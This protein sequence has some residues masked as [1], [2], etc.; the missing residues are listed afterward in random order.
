MLALAQPK[1]DRIG[2]VIK[3]KVMMVQTFV[4]KGEPEGEKSFW[5]TKG[6]VTFPIVRYTEEQNPKFK[7][8][9]IRQYHELLPIYNTMIKSY[10]DADTKMFVQALIRHEDEFR[11]LL[12]PDQLKVY[13]KALSDF[14]KDNATQADAYNSLFFSDSLLEE[15]RRRG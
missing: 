2:R 12:T 9:F 3:T 8:L 7:E 1:E 13:S 4:N 6:Q 14:E 11:A 5:Q 15:F 10:N